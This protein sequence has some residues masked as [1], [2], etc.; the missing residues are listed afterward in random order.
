MMM[1]RGSSSGEKTMSKRLS[2]GM[3]SSVVIMLAGVLCIPIAL[4]TD[5]HLIGTIA[6]CLDVGGA[7]G[8]LVCMTIMGINEIRSMR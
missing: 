8:C 2:I 5:N 6:S 3:L 4:M 7:G 1:T